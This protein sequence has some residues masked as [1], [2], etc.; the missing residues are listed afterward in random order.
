MG[1]P[2]TRRRKHI[3]FGSILAAVILVSG[4]AIV[5]AILPPL[6][7]EQLGQAMVETV[8]LASASY[9]S[10][11]YGAPAGTAM[12]GNSLRPTSSLKLIY[13]AQMSVTLDE[14]MAEAFPDLLTEKARAWNGYVSGAANWRESGQ[15]PQGH[16]TVRVP[17][18]RLHE[19][20]DWIDNTVTV[21]N[22]NLTVED[23][24]EQYVDLEARLANLRAAESRLGELLA[25]AKG[26]LEE[27][28]KVEQE[29][30]R[31]RG[32]IETLVGRKRYW[33]NHIA[34]STLTVS[35]RL[36]DIYHAR[37]LT[38][39]PFGRRVEL[40]LGS[41]WR[42]FTRA[43]A[44]LAIGVVYALPWLAIAAV[45]LVAALIRRGRRR[46]GV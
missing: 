24:S 2:R 44:A 43:M 16:I 35:Y 21:V 12:L 17:A 13:T 40:A 29:I 1:S 46:R 14:K 41:S 37:D 33:D 45:V 38:A 20:L 23:I 30:R 32:E 25:E 5:G 18:E 39:P 9:L 4:L 42:S 36:A 19:L 22:S 15:R 26:S 34:M 27:V 3:L 31:V 10:G 28:L 11:E 8:P 6:F 7:S